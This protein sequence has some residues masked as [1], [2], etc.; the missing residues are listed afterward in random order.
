[1]KRWIMAAVLVTGITAAT[2]ATAGASAFDKNDNQGPKGQISHAGNSPDCQ[3]GNGNGDTVQHT[4]V[5][6][7]GQTG[8]SPGQIHGPNNGAEF[9][10]S[11]CQAPTPPPTPPKPPTPPTPPV[12]VVPGHGPVSPSALAAL[13]PQHLAAAQA[14]QQAAQQ[15]A[16][17][18]QRQQQQVTVA[19]A[20]APVQTA[21]HFTG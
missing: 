15:Q 13:T 3:P 2:A 12:P 17:Q 7:P 16:A 6:P 20:A 19:P 5:G 10:F 9:D 21:A 4:H 18:Q 11:G 14:A 8:V 1:L